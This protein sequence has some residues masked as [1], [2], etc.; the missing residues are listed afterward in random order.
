MD[1]LFD[2]ETHVMI[3]GYKIR[4]LTRLSWG[5]EKKRIS[6]PLCEANNNFGRANDLVKNKSVKS[7]RPSIE[8]HRF[9]TQRHLAI[10]FSGNLENISMVISSIGIIDENSSASSRDFIAE[11]D[12]W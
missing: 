2:G 7:W 11:G 8:A 4:I 12:V 1:A 9:D 5:E 6:L 3:G 10:D